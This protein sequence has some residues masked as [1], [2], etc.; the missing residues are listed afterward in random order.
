MPVTL[1]PDAK[2]QAITSLTKFCEGEFEIEVSQIQAAS[3]LEFF[4]KEIAPSVYNAAVSDA[5]TFLHDRLGDME[6]TC[7]E[8]E[9]TWSSKGTRRK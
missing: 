4:L 2:K 9:F 7:F 8:P 5:K 1:A 6:A 3:L